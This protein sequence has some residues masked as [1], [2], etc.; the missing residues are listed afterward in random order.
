MISEHPGAGGMPLAFPSD[1]F[2]SMKAKVSDIIIYEAEL[3]L[4]LNSVL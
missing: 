4:R 3:E 2:K 1:F